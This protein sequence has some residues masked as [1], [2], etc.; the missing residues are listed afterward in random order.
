MICICRCDSS[1]TLT[2]TSIDDETRASDLEDILDRFTREFLA[3]KE[4]PDASLQL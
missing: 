2:G 4:G 1:P 3:G